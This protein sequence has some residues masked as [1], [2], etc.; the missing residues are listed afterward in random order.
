MFSPSRGEGAARVQAAGVVRDHRAGRACLEDGKVVLAYVA[1]IVEVGRRAGIIG[2]DPGSGWG[3]DRYEDAGDDA[4][5][6]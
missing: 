4:V 5:F 3:W 6:F 2:S 1:V